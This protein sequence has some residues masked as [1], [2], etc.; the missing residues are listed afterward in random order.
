MALSVQTRTL[1]FL[2]LSTITIILVVIN[3][4][5]ITP[6]IKKT[7]PLPQPRVGVSGIIDEINSQENLI[8]LSPQDQ[9]IK[10]KIQ[11]KVEDSTKFSVIFPIP[12]GSSPNQQDL[13]KSFSDLKVGQKIYVV[14]KEDLRKTDS[15]TAQLIDL[16]FPF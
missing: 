2:A 6:K 12:W 3:F 11:I 13:K 7:Q 4:L 15:V 9:E 5:L 10:Q 1:T 8:M 14:A 16:A